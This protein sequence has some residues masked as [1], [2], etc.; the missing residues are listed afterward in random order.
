MHKTRI[1]EAIT[2]NIRKDVVEL[3]KKYNITTK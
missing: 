1:A 2:E 3:A